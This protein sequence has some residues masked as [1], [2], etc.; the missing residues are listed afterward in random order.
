MNPRLKSAKANDDFSFFVTFT[1]G[2]K[3]VFDLKPF[4]DKGRFKEL[5]D[6][7]NFRRFRLEE[8]VITWYNELDIGPDTVYL[9]KYDADN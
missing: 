7:N 8:G 6:I 3:G 4:L 5:K 9:L 1:N 2:E